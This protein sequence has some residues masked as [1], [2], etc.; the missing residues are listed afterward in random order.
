MTRRVLIA[1][2]PLLLLTACGGGSGGG[3]QAITTPSSSSQSPSMAV[4][5][6]P[7]LD[8]SKPCDSVGI[9]KV[10]FAFGGQVE[11]GTTDPAQ[12]ARCTWAVTG[13]SYGDG[14]VS[15]S[16]AGAQ[17]QAAFDRAEAAASSAQ[18]IDGIGD[19]AFYD[20]SAKVLEVVSG[21]HVFTVQGTFGKA[22]VLETDKALALATIGALGS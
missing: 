6:T 16:F 15:V 7:T 8:P 13:S 12:P 5:A 4:R 17:T 18:K 20:P 22:D 2:A 11:P 9:D 19:G 10:V 21:D 3:T 1:A 14:K